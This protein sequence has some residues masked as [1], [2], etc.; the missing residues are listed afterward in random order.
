MKQ[1]FKIL[2]LIL[3][4]IMLVSGILLIVYRLPV[5]NYMSETV[6][7][8]DTDAPSVDSI[9]SSEMINLES[10]NS[11]RLGSLV[12]QVVNFDFDNICRRPASLIKSP[13]INA[14]STASSTIQTTSGCAL[15]NGQPFK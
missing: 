9:S 15:G 8:S 14:S 11:K 13:V 7:I 3:I 1:I 6:G 4:L 2:L 10:M 5:L 12:N